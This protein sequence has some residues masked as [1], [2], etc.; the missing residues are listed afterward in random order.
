ML[1]TVAGDRPLA[2]ARSACVIGP[3]ERSSPSSR[4]RFDARSSLGDPGSEALTR[5]NVGDRRPA[6]NRRWAAASGVASAVSFSRV[7]VVERTE[8]FTVG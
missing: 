7:T 1:D 5:A 8:T 2:R 6:R 3:R 4:W